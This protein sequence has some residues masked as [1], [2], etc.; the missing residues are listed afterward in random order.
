M[1]ALK[2][3]QLA[4]E[5]LGSGAR[6]SCVGFAAGI[7]GITAN[8]SSYGEGL[9]M[10]RRRGMAFALLL[11]TTKGLCQFGGLGRVCKRRTIV[12]LLARKCSIDNRRAVLLTP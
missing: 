8:I 10:C 12:Q 9:G 11:P 6:S 7:A 3:R 4:I 5:R 2:N 1:R